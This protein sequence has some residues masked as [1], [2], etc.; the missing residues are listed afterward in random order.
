MIDICSGLNENQKKAVKIQTNAVVA[1]GAGSGKTKVLASRYVYLITEKGF[2]VDAILALTFTEDAAA[3]MH[4]RIYQQLQKMQAETDNTVQRER[5]HT[6]LDSFFKAQIMTID[7]FCR[8]IAVTA[9]RKFGIS[10]DFTIDLD[11]SDR[12]ARNLSLDFFLEHRSDSSMQYFLGNKS[13]PDFLD[14]FFIKILTRYTAVS[15]PIDFASAFQMQQQAA[16]QLFHRF[17]KEAHANLEA[18]S[19]YFHNTDTFIAAVKEAY[20]TIPPIPVSIADP[21]FPVFLTGLEKLCAVKKTIGSRKDSEVAACKE[22]CA[23][24]AGNYA[25]LV[26]LYHF[27]THREDI[28]HIY[29]LCAELQSRYIAEKKRRSVVHFDDIAKLAVDA[30]I[31]DPELR[32]FYKQQ[33]QRIM[34]DEFQDNNSLQR[35]LLFLLAEKEERTVQSVPSASDLTQ[36]KLFFVGDEKQSIYAFRGA[37]VSVFR[38]LSQDLRRNNEAASINLQT[39]YRTEPALLN[40]FNT[41]F[42]QVFYSQEH[43]P[44]SGAVPPYEAEFTGILSRAAVE[45][46][47][48]QVDIL[49]ADE[50]R[51]KETALSVNEGGTAFLQS[52]ECEAYTL[53]RKMIAL[54]Q[55]KTAVYDDT[56]KTTRPC[57]WSDF[58]VLLRTSTRQAVYERFFRLCKIPYISVQQH[59]LFQ[60]APLNDLC[61]LLRLAVYPHDRSVYAQVLRSPFVQINDRSFTQLLLQ[62]TEPFAANA[63]AGLEPEDQPYFLSAC[64]LFERIKQYMQKKSNAELITAL[65][66]DEGYR[67]LLLRDMA[68]HRYLEL[69][70]YLFALAAEADSAGKSLAAFIDVLVSYIHA[71]Q[72]VSDMNIPLEHSG[73][74]VK[75]MTV[76]KSK[77]LEFPIVCIPDCGNEGRTETKEG[78][79]F[80]HQQL[81]PVLHL[82][83]DAADSPQANIFFEELRKEANAKLLAETKRLFYVALTRAKVRLL[84]SGVQKTD[85][86]PEELPENAR[87]AEE[88]ALHIAQPAKEENNKSFFQ[89]LM[90]ALSSGA[91]C[92]QFT[93]I[94]PLP[95]SSLQH[96]KEDRSPLLTDSALMHYRNAVEKSF[97]LA[98]PRVIPATQFEKD[99]K[100]LYLSD[101]KI[102]AEADEAAEKSENMPEEETLSKTEFGTLVHKAIELQFLGRFC[103]LPA[104]YEKEVNR[105]CDFFFSSP[106]GQKA[107]AACFRKTEYGFLTLYGGKLVIGQI[108][109]LFEYENTVYIV[110]Y[111]TD[112]KI[113]PEKHREQLLIYKAATENLYKM[114]GFGAAMDNAP[115]EPRK[116]KAYIFYLRSQTAIEV[117]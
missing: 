14:G 99:R 46:L 59:G 63:A 36:D 35:D 90:P 11:E 82:P 30:L 106:L 78:L 115:A 110:D 104:K 103:P 66:Y 62:K 116:I 61:A 38:T 52:V 81:G 113:Y 108:D 84:L 48:P 88:I 3:E 45:N 98:Q 97:P 37:D 22:L 67:Y 107:S 33:I 56:L 76:H 93:E 69:Y 54:Y 58:A 19:S 57:R 70:D 112:R 29:T 18:L 16:E 96:I 41:L 28:E 39:N 89:L 4:R 42:M 91:P 64:E 10:P 6:A 68:Y 32:L 79:V 92:V 15:R 83:Q 25:Q 80:L 77:G 117:E 95:L 60:D 21:Q 1:A 86:K 72:Q 73:D 71:E 34:I 20:Q 27:F 111:K 13:I 7:A 43:E 102:L 12:I 65:W 50:N 74:A 5:A 55:E 85:C 114:D 51:F 26:N 31:R 49:F 109:L 105:L 100:L 94:L 40:F 2:Q 8:K 75:I 101:E 24:L 87:S 9:C 44:T 17:Y 23:G 47:K 53:S